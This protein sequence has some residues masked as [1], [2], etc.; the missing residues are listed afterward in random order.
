MVQY[1][2]FWGKLTFKICQIR[3]IQRCCM[4][5]FS[6]HQILLRLHQIL[7]LLLNKLYELKLQYW[8]ND[9]LTVVLYPSIQILRINE[10]VTCW[11]CGRCI[12]LY[13]WLGNA[14]VWFPFNPFKIHLRSFLSIICPLFQICPLLLSIYF[15]LSIFLSIFSKN[16]DFLTFWPFFIFY[17][18]I[19][20]F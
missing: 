5:D 14:R 3:N 8:T 17:T 1:G 10:L 16:V 11:V 18:W 15:N 7:L 12:I 20:P 4:L 9:V 6:M 2:R 13:I 19:P